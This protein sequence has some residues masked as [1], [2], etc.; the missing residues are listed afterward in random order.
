MTDIRGFKRPQIDELGQHVRD[1]GLRIDV[2]ELACLN[3]RGDAGPILRAV[4]VA[5]A[6]TLIANYIVY[7]KP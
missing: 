5:G 1:V 4:V 7:A 6:P 2:I 3:Q